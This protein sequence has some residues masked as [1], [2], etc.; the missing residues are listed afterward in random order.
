M[1]ISEF[2][3]HNIPLQVYLAVNWKLKIIDISC[4]LL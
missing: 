2:H 1:V 4:Y 3:D